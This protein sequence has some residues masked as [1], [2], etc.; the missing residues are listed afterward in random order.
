MG[1]FFCYKCRRQDISQ[2]LSNFTNSSSKLLYSS[3]NLIQNIKKAKTFSENE[4]TSSKNI[5]Y[6][7]TI[8]NT[9]YKRCNSNPM[10]E[11][12]QKKVKLEDFKLIRLIG[13]GSY[14]KVYVAS[15]NSCKKLYAIKILNKNKINNKILKKNINTERTLLANL[16]HPF[17]MKLK[18][19]FQTKKSLYFI[20]HFMHG[21]EL[22]YHI[23]KEKNNYFSEEK[24]KFY[25]AEINLGLD[26]LHKNN[27]IY[28]D[29]KPENVLIDKDGHIKLT[30]FGLSKLCEDFP[31]KTNSLCGT[32][33][34]LAPEILFEKDYGIEVD[35]WSLGVL[36]YEMLSGYLPFRI[37][38]EE[39]IT[40]NVYKKKIKI[41]N[42]F[43]HAA[44]DLVKKLL[45]YNP[46]KRIGFE[47]IINHSFFK[48]INWQEIE[49]KE[50]EPPFLPEIDKNIFKYFNTENE[51]NEEFNAHEQK[52]KI[53]NRSENPES[54]KNNIFDLDNSNDNNIIC[55]ENNFIENENESFILNKCHN[56]K[57]LFNKNND[58]DNFYDNNEALNNYIESDLNI[59]I[60][61]EDTTNF[62]E[63]NDNYFPSFSF[64]TLE[65][66]EEDGNKLKI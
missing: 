52:I 56:C 37:I 35:W 16:N 20:T 55:T 23:Y 47:Q 42:H 21:G 27:C 5:Q 51:L 31:C 53:L 41:F 2:S 59:G 38:P 11:I 13:I 49:K 15:K 9:N 57:Y 44:K 25:A 28:R 19:A 65:D 36:I 33:E 43:S 61:K 10:R 66:E 4:N 24:T 48:D 3:N 17:I 32:P 63:I 58:N 18:Y 62:T 22:N 6:K 40:K 26:Y 14:G 46:K 54:Y 12:M 50:I 39:K 1:L 7:D 60:R 29:L 30:D 64:S 45:E 8:K 34:Y